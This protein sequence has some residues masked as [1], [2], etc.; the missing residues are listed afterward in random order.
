MQNAVL[1]AVKNEKGNAPMPND[2]WKPGPK[3]KPGNT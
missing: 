3:S 2:M 1:T